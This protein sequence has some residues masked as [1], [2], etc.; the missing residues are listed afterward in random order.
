LY[1]EENKQTNIT[2]TQTWF[3]CRVGV[4]CKRC[5]GLHVVYIDDLKSNDSSS[6]W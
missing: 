2:A 4:L 1:Q 6:V 5:I 3:S